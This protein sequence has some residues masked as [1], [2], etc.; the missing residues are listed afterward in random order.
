MMDKGAIEQIEQTAVLA[1]GV[2]KAFDSHIPITLVPKGL[3][4]ISLEKYRTQPARFRGRFATNYISDFVYYIH[5]IN[6]P[7]TQCFINADR[8]SAEAYFDLGDT[9][10]PGHGE[11][12][13]ILTLLK[14][15]A[16]QSAIEITGDELKQKECAEWLEDWRDQ[17]KLYDENDQ[18]VDIKRG[19]MAVRQIKIKSSVESDHQQEQFKASRTTA[20]KIEALNPEG[21]LNYIVFEC[22]PY[23]QLGDYALTIKISIVQNHNEPR[24]KLR[25][26]KLEAVKEQL[27]NDFKDVLMNTLDENVKTYVGSFNPQ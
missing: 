17:I 4:L 1:S 3:E 20:E 13:A 25:I 21:L 27:A 11:H 6:E 19:I 2:A 9:K 10:Q 8:M 26:V 15:A 24:L 16:Y 5:V 22:Q 12:R 18:A 7:Y 14:T 23:H